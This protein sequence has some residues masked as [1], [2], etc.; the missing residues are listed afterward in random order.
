[1]LQRLYINNFRCLDNFDLPVNE[2]PSVLLI[3]KNGSGKSTIRV[4][5][6][7]L[8]K[9]GRGM[10]RVGKL[11]ERK[12]FGWERFNLP[13]RFEIEVLLGGQLYR[14]VLALE[15]PEK[16]KESRVLEEQLLVAGVPLYM[17][18][19]HKSAQHIDL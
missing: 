19:V 17:A 1:M 14:Y 9:I 6:E 5:L 10:N 12:D 7:V 13:I 15:L 8:Q 11:V 2:M 4:A 18:L 3:G 16:F